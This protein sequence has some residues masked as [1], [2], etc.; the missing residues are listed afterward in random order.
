MAAV[1]PRVICVPPDEGDT[2]GGNRTFPPPSADTGAFPRHSRAGEMAAGQEA[3]QEDSELHAGAPPIPAPDGGLR[4]DR[5]GPRLASPQGRGDPAFPLAADGSVA[6]GDNFLPADDPWP[7]QRVSLTA[8]T[9]N[10][11]KAMRL[12]RA[13]GRPLTPVAR[14]ALEG[15]CFRLRALA[16]RASQTPA[17]FRE[18]A[19]EQ[20]RSLHRAAKTS[21]APYLADNTMPPTET[22]STLH[23]HLREALAQADSRRI[24][25]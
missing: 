6:S 25:S 13:A 19:A 1:A 8:A 21:L 4:Q 12:H 9:P 10:L 15:T 2:T 20:A 18:L 22:I 3:E 5:D 16:W 7:G 14:Q 11:E 23:T 24:T 17:D